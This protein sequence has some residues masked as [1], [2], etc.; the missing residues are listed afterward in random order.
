MQRRAP[1]FTKRS[2]RAWT[3]SLTAGLGQ[4]KRYLPICGDAIAYRVELTVS[5][6]RSGSLLAMRMEL[7]E[8]QHHEQAILARSDL[9]YRSIVSNQ[10]AMR[11]FAEDLESAA[12]VRA[13]R[14]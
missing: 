1:M 11:R 12:R 7:Q 6:G 14:K 10:L 13:N 9:G 5:A 4:P 3:I 2:G 8:H